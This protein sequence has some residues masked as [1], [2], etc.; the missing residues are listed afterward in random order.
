MNDFEDE[1]DE[2]FEE[3]FVPVRAEFS[4][5]T[6]ENVIGVFRIM[7]VTAYDENDNEEDYTNI[8][9]MEREF[10]SRAAIRKAIASKLKID[11]ETVEF[12]DEEMFETPWDN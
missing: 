11:P 10:H 4:V 6:R 1:F 9:D 12:E 7:S 8:F 5:D 3:D 2:E